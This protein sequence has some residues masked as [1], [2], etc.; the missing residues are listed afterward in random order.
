MPSCITLHRDIPE[1]VQTVDCIR[2]LS[3]GGMWRF[4]PSPTLQVVGLG[5]GV[6]PWR[7]SPFSNLHGSVL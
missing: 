3:G 4:S 1:R 7:K 5:M 6:S 2:M